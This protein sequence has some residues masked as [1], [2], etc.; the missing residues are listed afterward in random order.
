MNAGEILYA[1]LLGVI[2]VWA[3]DL[4][5][6]WEP[7]AAALTRWFNALTGRSSPR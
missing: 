5:H 7:W 6:L 3:A 2:L 4:F 1:V